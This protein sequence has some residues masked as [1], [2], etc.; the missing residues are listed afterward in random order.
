MIT[1]D[2]RT[3][4]YRFY[5]ADDVL[6]YVGITHRLGQRWSEHAR[7]QPWWPEVRRQTAEWYA[8]R[9]EAEAAEITAIQQEDPRHN[10]VRIPIPCAVSFADLE[11]ATGR[12]RRTKSARDEAREEV[13]ERVVAAL[14]AG[15]RPTDVVAR[16]PF[17]GAYVRRIAREH[18]IEG[19]PRGVKE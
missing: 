18:G 10:I 12:Y 4:L 17:T 15:V 1:T 9:S 8:T 2:T 3:A 19:K 5:G 7:S 11:A 14:R 13:I 16:S 6:L